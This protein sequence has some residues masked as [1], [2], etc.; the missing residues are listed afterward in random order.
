MSREFEVRREVELEATPEQ[1][2]EA[3]ATGPGLAAWFMPMEPAPNGAGAEV[4][5]PPHRLRIRT[6]EAEDGSFQ[7]FDYLV[8]ARDGGSAV[9]RFVHS[10]MLDGDW[11]DE[12]EGMTGQGWDMY[13]HTLGEYLRHFGGRPAVYAEAEAPADGTWPALLRELGLTDAAS[14]G[15]VVRLTPDGLPPVEGVIDYLTPAFLGIRTG[16]A[17]VRFHGRAAIG[18][19]I[20]VGHHHYTAGLDPKDAEAAWRSWLER[21]AP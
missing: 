8:E 15:D 3:I 11:A 19:P 7:A 2:W 10:G 17:L 21:T 9:L 18:L 6:P 13:L 12:F 4:W 20:A 14:V 5:D 1:V 16:D